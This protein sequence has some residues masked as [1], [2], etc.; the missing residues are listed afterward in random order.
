MPISKRIVDAVGGSITV[1]TKKRRRH[2][3]YYKA[4]D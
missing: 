2:G 3:V 1:K 4:A